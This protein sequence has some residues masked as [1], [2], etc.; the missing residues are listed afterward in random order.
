MSHRYPPGERGAMRSAK[1]VFLCLTLLGLSGAGLVLLGSGPSPDGP[2]RQLAAPEKAGWSAWISW[3]KRGPSPR[4]S[5]RPRSWPSRPHMTDVTTASS[6][7]GGMSLRRFE[8]HSVRKSLVSALA[9]IAVAEK[10]LKTDAT[11]ADLGIDDDPASRRRREDGQ[12]HRPP[13]L[14]LRDLSSRGQGDRGHE[15]EP[16]GPRQ[17]QARRE[18][19]LQ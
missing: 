11:L 15:D 9:G 4:R 17:R 10:K 18:M 14:P 1:S 7:P 19:A 2:W 5:A 6:S 12:G 13:P 8:L 3:P 16:A